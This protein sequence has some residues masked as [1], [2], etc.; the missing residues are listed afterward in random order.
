MHFLWSRARRCY[1][2][3]AQRL[4]LLPLI[5]KEP[6]SWSRSFSR[7]A[8]TRVQVVRHSFCV[9]WLA[10]SQSVKQV[11]SQKATRS[12]I[13][14]MS[15]ADLFEDGCVVGLIGCATDLAMADSAA[16]QRT[17]TQTT[18][19]MISC[20]LDRGMEPSV[21]CGGAKTNT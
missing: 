21:G 17:R 7:S 3:Y 20:P 16:R 11:V 6:G 14:W 1:E 18:P 8:A 10:A 9:M 13:S 2:P 4:P 19:R 5:V 15:L 12:F